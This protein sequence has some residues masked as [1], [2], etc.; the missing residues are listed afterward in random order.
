MLISC[1]ITRKGKELKTPRYANTAATRDRNLRQSAGN[2]WQIASTIIS[3][4]YSLLTINNTLCL[5]LDIF[6]IAYVNN[7]LVYSNNLAKY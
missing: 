2:L 3:P 6:C 1:Y 4:R 7:I 5:Y